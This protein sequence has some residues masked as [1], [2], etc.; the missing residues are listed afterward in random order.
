MKD[1]RS[2]KRSKEGSIRENK[3]G[4]FTGRVQY[5]DD[6][7]RRKEFTK[8]VGGR[9]EAWKAIKAMRQELESHGEQLL[10]ADK[11]TFRDLADKFVKTC[12]TQAKYQG[13]KKIHGRKSIQPVMSNIKAL[14]NGFG[15]KAIKN[16]RPSDIEAYKVKRLETPVV[17]EFN[18][19]V[20]IVN[21]GRK[22][23]TVEKRQV[24]RERKISSVNRELQLLRTMFRFAVR[25]KMLISSPFENHSIIST[26][27]ELSRER[28]L[29]LEEERRLLAAFE[30]KQHLKALIIT[31]VDT[32]MRRGELFKLCWGDV[33]F[34]SRQI[35]IQATN[36]KTEKERN[37]GMTDRVY[38]ELMGLWELSSKDLD[39]LVFG[40]RHTIKTSWKTA[41]IK[42]GL[43]DLHF[44]DLRHTA[45][46]RLI[47]AGVPHT[48]AMK[49]TGHTQF[50][51][52]QR[53][54][55]LTNE[56]VAASANILNEYLKQH[57]GAPLEAQFFSAVN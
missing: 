45:T 32:A 29:S 4:T 35:T 42:A 23:Y 39:E 36:A 24:S 2:E 6:N 57:N 15:N 8:T 40:I 22:K 7:G 30:G 50:K 1:F 19:K 55:N 12:V 5:I 13:G 51:T 33:D 43:D 48:E 9:R 52:F 38:D 10:K 37:V 49:I 17:V 31:A 56:S 28:I 54:M 27:A 47:R 21:P 46:T 11:I 34:E 14:I 18:V 20:P 16:I 44:H 25:D 41:C 53:Y 3:N 26:A